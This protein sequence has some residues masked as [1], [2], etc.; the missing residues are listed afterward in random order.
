MNLFDNVTDMTNFIINS[1]VKIGDTVLDLTMGNGNDTLYLAKK[2]SQKG[3]VYSF[4]IQNEAV[5][6]TS[7]LLRENNI[8]NAVLIKD[9]HKNVLNYVKE[10]VDFGVYNLGY[11]PG[12][13][14][15]IVTKSESTVESLKNVIT[16]LNIKG[17]ICIC[18]YVGHEGGYEEYLKVKEYCINLPKRNFNVLLLEHI[19]RS[20]NAPRMIIIEKIK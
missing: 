11:L 8:K 3:K 12:Y 15:H 10:K 7:K 17:I 9:N 18:A 1:K 16:L 14:K 2:V 5:E 20:E 4:D 13:D 6:N 19:N